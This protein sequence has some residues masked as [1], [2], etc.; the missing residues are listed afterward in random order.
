MA[1]VKV[2]FAVIYRWRLRSGMEQQFQAAWAT[3]TKTFM[4]ERRALGSRL[5][6]D[7]DGYWVAY[8]QWPSRRAWE[9]SRKLGPADP[10]VSA[11]MAEAIEES[12]APMA[13][14]PVAD[15]LVVE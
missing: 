4:A 1:D 7:D 12:F 14:D 2:G 15:Y 13:L 10:K 9:Q 8:A 6:R 3:V 11:A 5:H